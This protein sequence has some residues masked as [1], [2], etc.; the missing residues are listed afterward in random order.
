[1]NEDH[2]HRE[3]KSALLLEP[4]DTGFRASIN[5]ISRGSVLRSLQ[6]F[7]SINA[8]ENQ[9]HLHTISHLLTVQLS[10]AKLSPLVQCIYSSLVLIGLT[11]VAG[12]PLV[13]DPPS[14][15]CQQECN[16]AFA[17][18]DDT[19]GASSVMELFGEELAW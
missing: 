4:K 6:S 5:C 13:S 8:T 1:M 19:A 10:S 9:I 17:E 16:D 18:C 15:E 14:A 11:F 3:K 7:A 2:R 12:T